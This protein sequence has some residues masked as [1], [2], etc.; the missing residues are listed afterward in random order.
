M[1]INQASFVKG[2][3]QISQLPEADRPEVA[4]VGRS[5]V[6]K[7]SLINALTNHKGLARISATPGKTREINHFLINE[8][9]YL[10]DLPGYGYAK[11]G[12]KQRAE[13]QEMIIDYAVERA[14]LMNLF[15]LVDCRIPPQKIDMEF[16]EFLN[17]EQ[18]PYA[19]IFTKS[20]KPNQKTLN[21]NL[22]DFKQ[23]L[24]NKRIPHP[25]M[26][27]TSAEKKRGLGEVLSYIEDL[28]NSYA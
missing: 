15:V 3:V 10:A 12:K 11:V 13:F 28:L 24:I 9:W 6:G 27:L 2:S 20:D 17:N 23:A 18:V 7:S 14:N 26:M 19:I 22:K 8:Q 4:F 16:C 5:N 21:K 25:P 1:Q